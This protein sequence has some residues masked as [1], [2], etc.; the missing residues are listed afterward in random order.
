MHCL[1]KQ[2][3]TPGII[4]EFIKSLPDSITL[5]LPEDGE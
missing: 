2:Q 3:Y 5:N 1:N 4:T